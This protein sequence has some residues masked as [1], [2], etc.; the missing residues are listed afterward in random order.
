VRS[1]EAVWE[2][3]GGAPPVPAEGEVDLSEPLVIDAGTYEGSGFWSSG[4]LWSEAYVEYTLRFAAPGD[5]PYACLIH[6][7]MVGTVRVRE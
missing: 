2:A 1:N 5:Y 6:P 3:A 7:P 4:V